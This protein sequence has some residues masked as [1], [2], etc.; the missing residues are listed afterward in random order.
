MLS[1]ANLC[2]TRLAYP[3]ASAMSEPFAFQLTV[4]APLTSAV[5]APAPGSSHS[6]PAN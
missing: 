1:R 5:T 4:V 2:A 6:L 3:Y